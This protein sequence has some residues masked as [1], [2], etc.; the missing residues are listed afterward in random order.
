[1][2][3]Q[4]WFDTPYSYIPVLKSPD[5]PGE[6][7]T[8]GNFHSNSRKSELLGINEHNRNEETAR[9]SCLVCRPSCIPAGDRTCYLIPLPNVCWIELEISRVWLRTP[10]KTYLSAC[11]FRS[12]SFEE[13]S[14]IFWNAFDARS[15]TSTRLL[16]IAL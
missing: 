8:E 3:C 12:K 15:I 7:S 10:A 13:V 11:S 6:P 1:M 9:Q 2:A 14:R 5:A 16:R 4:I